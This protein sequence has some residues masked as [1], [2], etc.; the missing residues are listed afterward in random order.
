MPRLMLSDHQYERIAP[1]LL[2]KATDPGRTATDNR[3]F[4]EAVLWIVR[5]RAHGAI[6]LPISDLGTVLVPGAGVAH[7]IACRRRRL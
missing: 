6:Y 5:T 7:G 2:G 1:L 3:L 4:V